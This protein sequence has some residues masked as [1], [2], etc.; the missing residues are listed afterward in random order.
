[1]T[2]SDAPSPEATAPADP[3]AAPIAP[4][5]NCPA[6]SAD[7]AGAPALPCSAAEWALKR[8]G[9]CSFVYLQNAPS[10]RAI[11]EHYDWSRTFP[12]ERSRRREGHGLRYLLSD[13]AKR[14]KYALRGG[15]GGQHLKVRRFI[16]R[17]IPDG[18]LLDVGCSRGRTLMNLR[19]GLT[20]YGIEI[21]HTLAGLARQVCEPRGGRVVRSNA[22][23]GMDEFEDDFFDG[24]VMRAFLEHE[25]RPLELLRRSL[26]VLKVRGVIIIKVPN[27]G[28]LNRRLYGRRWCGFRFPDHV[29]Y[30]TPRT[31]TRMVR[32]AGLQ[33]A[34]FGL[35]ERWPLS[36]NMWMVARKG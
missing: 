2:S 30:F 6:C 13:A 34:R 16:N 1:M 17:H 8:C 22:I 33:V 21:S 9:A 3:A 12:E 5:R 28:S 26:R 20:P 27:Y 25:T 35:L 24:I 7:N 10:Y 14:I 32:D 11:E 36:D 23:C 18:R 19:E 15:R 31:L 4:K 29:N